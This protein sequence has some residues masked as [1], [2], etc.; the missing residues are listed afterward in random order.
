[1]VRIRTSENGRASGAGKLRRRVFTKNSILAGRK[2][3]RGGD[4]ACKTGHVRNNAGFPLR[5]GDDPIQCPQLNK[6]GT[7]VGGGTAGLK[8]G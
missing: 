5:K 4:G 6:E 3:R 1:V 7:G 2:N 8:D